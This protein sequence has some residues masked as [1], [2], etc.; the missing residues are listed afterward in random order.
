MTHTEVPQA[1]R[2]RGVG[3][4]L[5]VAALDD[6]RQRGEVVQPDCPFV[7]RYIEEHPEVHDLL[8]R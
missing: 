6:V 4:R 8:R 3:E 7:R 1:M 2:G 5:V